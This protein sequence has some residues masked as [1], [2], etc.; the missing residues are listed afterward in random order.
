MDV[1]IHSLSLSNSVLTE[2]KTVTYITEKKSLN[3]TLVHVMDY[4]MRHT[5]LESV[6]LCKQPATELKTIYTFKLLYF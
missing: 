6:Y 1:C 5:L 4:E 2:S 3:V